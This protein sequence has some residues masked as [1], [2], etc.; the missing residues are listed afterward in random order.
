MFLLENKVIWS[1]ENNLIPDISLL[2]LLVYLLGFSHAFINPVIYI[3]FNGFYRKEFCRILKI[4]GNSDLDT[5]SSD[6]RRLVKQKENTSQTTVWLKWET[7]WFFQRNRF[8][9][10]I[11]SLIILLH[12][13][14]NLNKS[15]IKSL[16]VNYEIHTAHLILTKNS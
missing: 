11:S 12:F 8:P 16:S 3:Y 14:S 13:Q 2:L 10:C 9:F 4:K 5:S 7:R 1:D 6:D 15:T